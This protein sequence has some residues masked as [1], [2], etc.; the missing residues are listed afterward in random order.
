MRAFA[1]RNTGCGILPL[2][3]SRRPSVPPL[4]SLR[5]RLSITATAALNHAMIVSISGGAPGATIYYTTDGSAPTAQSTHYLAP[6]LVASD[7][8]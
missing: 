7:S 1:I 6:F 2:S 8:P 5:P 3:P 4:P